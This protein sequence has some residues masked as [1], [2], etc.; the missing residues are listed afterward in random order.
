VLAARSPVFE[1]QL[2]GA[3]ADARVPSITVQDMEPAAFRAM[4]HLFACV[5]INRGCDRSWSLS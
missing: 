5:A 3:M 2:L 4:L 1:A